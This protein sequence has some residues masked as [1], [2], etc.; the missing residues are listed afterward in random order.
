MMPFKSHFGMSR[1]PFHKEDMQPKDA[2]ESI[3]HL[4]LQSGLSYLVKVKGIG[5]ITAPSGYGKTFAIRCFTASLDPKLH[6][7]AYICL[8][9]VSVPEFYKELGNAVNADRKCNKTDMFNAIRFQIRQYNSSGIRKPFI[10]IIDEAQELSTHILKDLK[11]LTN[12]HYDSQYCFTLILCGTPELL[13]HL[14][15]D[16]HEPLRQR[17]VY[18]YALEGLADVEV[19][20]YVLHKIALSGASTEIIAEE[21]MNALIGGCERKV[22]VID[23]AMTAALLICAQ[24]RKERID[25]AIMQGAIE[26]LSLG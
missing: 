4:E 26:S 25:A 2:Y 18:H 24:K 6:T 16:I 19:R 12:F 22:R 20:E 15:R 21:A 10:I 7:P 1:N 14:N 17:I 3:D 23:S 8:S 11:L 13:D 5:V 9:T